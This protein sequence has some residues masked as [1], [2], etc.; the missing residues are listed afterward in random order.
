M[1]SSST[2]RTWRSLEQVSIIAP[3]GIRFWDP[4]FDVSVDDDLTVIAYPDGA[5]RPA[6]NAYRTPDGIYAFHGLPGLHNVEY[7]AGDS[8]GPG[9]LPVA[10]RF[11]IEVSDRAARF[12]PVSF[13]VD[14]P[15]KGIFPTDLPLASTMTALPGFYLFSAPT[16]SATP[17]GTR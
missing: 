13:F 10:S 1:T 9:S 14:A 12:L 15:S 8:D 7:P 11:L 5:R 17:R 2:G 16:R 3:L 4:A 6:T